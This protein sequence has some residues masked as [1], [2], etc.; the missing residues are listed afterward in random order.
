M[1]SFFCISEIYAVKKEPSAFL[2]SIQVIL[3]SEGHLCP[4]QLLSL[5]ITLSIIELQWPEFFFKLHSTTLM[6]IPV[7]PFSTPIIVLC[8]IIFYVCT[9]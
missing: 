1:K 3:Y 2:K 7:L 6:L 5:E 4:L 9:V 8:C